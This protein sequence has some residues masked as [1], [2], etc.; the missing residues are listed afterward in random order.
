MS[1]R[2]AA[3]LVITIYLVGA[4]GHLIPATLPLILSTT[5]YILFGLGLVVLG[6]I[7]RGKS[8]AFWL[9]SV[10]TCAFTFMLEAIGVATSKIFGPYTYGA[11]LGPKLWG[12]PILI[13]LNWLL[14][15]IGAVSLTS[16]RVKNPVLFVI[17]IGIL[18]LLFD[19]VMEPVA[20][21]LGYW[22]WHT[23]SIPLQN[24]L[25][26]FLVGVVSTGWY[27][28]LHLRMESRMAA[29][30]MLVQMA[31]FVVLHVFL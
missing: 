30:Y 23:T 12:V 17:V 8:L 1:E 27:R 10:G 29:T 14:V 3:V 15:I 11:V 19:Y 9:W 7:L 31:F 26:W 20:T 22:Q 16:R 2:I 18:T 21:K 6:P 13:S 28:I 5:P 25:I 24:Y 4:I